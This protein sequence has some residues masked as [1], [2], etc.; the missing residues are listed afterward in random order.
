MRAVYY[1]P[2]VRNQKSSYQIRIIGENSKTQN[3]DCDS[4]ITEGLPVL[5]DERCYYERQL[6][7][8]KGLFDVICV[9]FLKI[10]IKELM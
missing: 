8:G 6:S 5:R 9:E 1:E 2:K 10:N 4:N 7:L 3:F